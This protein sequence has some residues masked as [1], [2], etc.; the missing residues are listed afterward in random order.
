MTDDRD[1]AAEA[2]L[3]GQTAESATSP[4]VREERVDEPLLRER[5][6]AIARDREK[7]DAAAQAPALLSR[8]A[9][10]ELR[11]RWTAIQTD[12]VDEPRHAV[13]Q[14]DALVADAIAHLSDSF[15]TARAALERDWDRGGDV[16]TEDLRLALR[17]YRAFFHRLL[18]I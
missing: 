10:D 16:S 15:A 1:L 13:E 9:I 17:R 12:F 2:R 3:E 18:S 14:A 4:S 5:E 11:G 6:V 7:G 8:E